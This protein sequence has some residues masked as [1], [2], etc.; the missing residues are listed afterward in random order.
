MITPDKN[1]RM[2][3]L[4]KTRVALGRFG[5]VDNKH[6]FKRAMIDSQLTEES[7]RRA[8]LKS[9]GPGSKDSE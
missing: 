6:A 3:K 9:K 7:S 5:S 8:A 4:I 1:Y 2:T